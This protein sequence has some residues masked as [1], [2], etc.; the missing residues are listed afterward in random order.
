M[1]CVSAVSSQWL[2]LDDHA[3]STKPLHGLC[4]ISTKERDQLIEMRCKYEALTWL[5]CRF[6]LFAGEL[7][8]FWLQVRS[9]YMACVS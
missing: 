5:V 4:V 7:W 3:A 6:P 1:A 2:R 9:P 8:Q